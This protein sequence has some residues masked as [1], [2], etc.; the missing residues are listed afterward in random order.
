MR[1]L[2]RDVFVVNILKICLWNCYIYSIPFH[3]KLILYGSGHNVIVHKTF[4]FKCL[5]FF[6]MCIYIWILIVGTTANND[7]A[8]SAIWKILSNQ[9]GKANTNFPL[10]IAVFVCELYVFCEFYY[11]YRTSIYC[12]IRSINWKNGTHRYCVQEL[13]WN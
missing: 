8:A 6:F 1:F 9:S 11:F 13:N 2:Y 10:I 12:C 4:Q 7:L 3:F 5:S